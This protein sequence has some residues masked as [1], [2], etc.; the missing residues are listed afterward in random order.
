[1]LLKEL[2]V[3]REIMRR[4]K[5]RRSIACK[6]HPKSKKCHYA[7]IRLHGFI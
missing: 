1:M 6:I 3:E 7:G 5:E 4:R 2:R